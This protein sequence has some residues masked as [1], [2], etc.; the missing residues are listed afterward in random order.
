VTAYLNI[1]DSFEKER[2]VELLE[3]VRSAHAA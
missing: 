2:L 1:P 3:A